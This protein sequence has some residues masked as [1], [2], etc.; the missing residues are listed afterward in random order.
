MNDLR[1]YYLTDVL[2]IDQVT[3]LGG[4][5]RKVLIDGHR[6]LDAVADVKVNSISSPLVSVTSP[7][8][9]EVQVPN[10]LQSVALTSL[11]FEVLSS[12]ATGRYPTRVV[13]DLGAQPERVSGFDLLVQLVLRKLLLTPATN[14]ARPGEGVGLGKIR[15]MVLARG[16]AA[17]L[18]SGI[19]DGVQRVEAE[20]K[21][22][23]VGDGRYTTE[24]RLR[25]LSVGGTTVDEKGGSIH[26]VL[27]LT[28]EAGRNRT[29]PLVL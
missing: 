21:E 12:R 26:V 7:T 29:V 4:T 20:L 15:G 14:R 1:F 18:Q 10:P 13:L 2:A 11:T 9:L 24:E 22:L 17:R 23:Q 6:G 25:S 5:P 8:Q 3:D 19:I 27:R 16:D 28:S